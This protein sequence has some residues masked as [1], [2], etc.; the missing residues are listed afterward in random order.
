MG[1][2]LKALDLFSGLISLDQVLQGY[3]SP[4][5]SWRDGWGK[6]SNKSL[7]CNSQRG[8]MP[9]FWE[10]S[11][12]DQLPYLHHKPYTSLKSQDIYGKNDQSAKFAPY[13]LFLQFHDILKFSQ[14]F[15][16]R[17]FFS[18]ELQIGAHTPSNNAVD[19]SE[20]YQEHRILFH[21]TGIFGVNKLGFLFFDIFCFGKLQ[22]KLFEKYNKLQILS[23]R[24][25]TSLILGVLIDWSYRL[26]SNVELFIYYG[27]IN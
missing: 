25:Y 15:V 13:S 4:A 19:L 22:N 2:H 12:V 16:H 9:H 8:P 6:V 23:H 7:E 18:K 14:G 1:V 27:G 21:R 11:D 26:Y 17:T 24:K 10:R 5:Q 3:I 20:I